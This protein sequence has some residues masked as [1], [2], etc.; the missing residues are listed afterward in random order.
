M[1][2]VMYGIIYLYKQNLMNALSKLQ[3]LAS[4]VTI[5]VP[6]SFLL[7]SIFFKKNGFKL[8]LYTGCP[9]RYETFLNVNKSPTFKLGIP[10]Y[11]KYI[12]IYVK[13]LFQGIASTI[14][15]KQYVSG[16]VKYGVA[17]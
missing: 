3:I 6:V 17:K 7:C 1:R 4:H 8:W 9:I 14:L 16:N 11:P 15:C 12:I 10:K 2:S 5:G 13:N